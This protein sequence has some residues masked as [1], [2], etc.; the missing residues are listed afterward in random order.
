LQFKLQSVEQQAT[1]LEANYTAAASI[2]EEQAEKLKL[3]DQKIMTLGEASSFQVGS[4]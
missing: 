2:V 1:D 4:S 3:R